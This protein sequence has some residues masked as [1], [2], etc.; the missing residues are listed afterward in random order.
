MPPKPPSEESLR[1]TVSGVA[2]SG[3]AAA[4][5]RATGRSSRTIRDH[6]ERA[7]LQGIN[8]PL[9]QYAIPDG[10]HVKGVSTLYDADGTTRATWV[11]TSED[12]EKQEQL[13]RE[14]IAAFVDAIPPAKKVPSPKIK[15]DDLCV[16][17]CIGDAHIGLYAW[18]A[19]TGADFDISIAT[20]DLR[21]AV[22]R[23]VGS[24][25]A[26]SEAIVVQLG[27]FYHVDSSKQST[28]MGGNLLDVDS[29][30]PKVIRAGIATMRHM[31]DRALEKHN[32]VRVRNVA[33]NHDPH[34][35]VTLTEALI[36][37]YSKE[38]R[39]IV[40]DSPKPFWHY[41][42]GS[43]LIGIT[44]GHS[45]K[46]ERLPGLL[47]VDAQSDWGECE[48]RYVWHGHIHSKR[49]FEDMGVIVEAFRTLAARDAW[50]TEQGYRPGREMQAIVL[51]KDWGEIERHT[52][53]LKRVRS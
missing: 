17:Y 6:I 26:S 31:I 3:S 23:L 43:N 19:E 38:P 53:G 2:R 22:D 11:K 21:L 30:F 14:T 51:H 32:T 49:V 12:R 45:G 27:D 46:P 10:F 52:A 37:Y 34:A 18:G 25:P 47:A 44:H 40:E 41:R 50:H 29:R 9:D 20:D 36:G 7:T 24:T 13:I 1:E 28:P 8:F 42:F 5:A 39:V 35:S 33:G 48:F 15:R 4:F 16:A